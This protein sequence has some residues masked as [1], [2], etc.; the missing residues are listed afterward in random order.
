MKKLSI[1]TLLFFFLISG[2]SFAQNWETLDSGTD[3]ILFDI[4]FPKGQSEIGYAAGMQYTWDAEGIVIKTTNGGDTWNQ[5]LGGT[6]TNGIETICFI[7][8]D[9]GFIAGWNNYFAKTTNG[10]ESWTQITVGSNNWYFMDIEFWDENNGIA[11]ANLSSG[12]IGVYI[13]NNG[14]NTWTTSLG[15]E[16]N[17]QD[18]AYADV[19]TL[20]AVGGDEKISKSTNGGM[21]W[22]QIYSGTNNRYFMGV[23]FNGNFGVI[24]GEDGKIIHTTDGGDNWN[25]YAT[26]YHNFQGVHVFN[27]DSA[28]I[29]GTDADIYKTT[30]YGDTWEVEDNG[31]ESSH[32]YKVKFTTDHTGFICGSQGLIKRKV[33]P[34]IILAADFEAD[35]IETCNWMPVHFTDLSTG[36]IENWAWDFGVAGTST[37]Q[38]PNITFSTP[39][40]YDITLTVYGDGQESSIT[41]EAYITSYI[42]PGFAEI[43]DG[44]THI[45][46]NPTNGLIHISGLK[47]EKTQVQLFDISGKLILNTLLSESDNQWDVSSIK[48]GIYFLEIEGFEKKEKLIIE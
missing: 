9:T 34:E 23:D 17:V 39:G 46:P 20:Y 28:Y 12:G 7:N 48:A 29:A 41:K 36:N 38:N 14:G 19:N 47:E 30:N 4:S 6:G 11:F 10:G 37:E 42:C 43:N 2:T 5:I 8:A 33:A 26:G 35:A 15:V 45:S 21:S 32:I 16:Q 31:P 44:Q 22:T 18:I 1:K 24:G 25:T 3:Y 27:S 40:V 13:T